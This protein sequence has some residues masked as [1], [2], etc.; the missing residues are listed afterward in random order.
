LSYRISE[1]LQAVTSGDEST[2][3]AMIARGA[4]VDATNDSGQTPLILAIVGG[5][6]RVLRHLMKAGANPLLRD[7]TGLNAIEWAERK[8]RPDLAQLLDP[9]RKPS[10]GSVSVS[11]PKPQVTEPSKEP[12]RQTPLSPEE[13]SRRFLA[14]LRQRFEEKAQLT[15]NPNGSAKEDHMQTQ[16]LIDKLPAVPPPLPTKEEISISDMREPERSSTATAA[17]KP[18]TRKRCPECNRIY[19]SELLS[20]C[21]YHIVPL[22]DANEPVAAPKPTDASPLFWTLVLVTLVAAALVGLLITNSLFENASSPKPA[23]AAL[24][25]TSKKGIPVLGQELTGKAVQLPEAQPPANAVKEPTTVTVRVK[26]GKDGRVNA[27]V[28]NAAE[29][30]VRESAIAAARQATFSVEKLRARSAEG[31]IRYTFNP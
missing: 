22:V 3:A 7:N 17:T 15:K 26:I 30:T 24:T 20:Y 29:R 4:D 27:A 31:T 8:G 5:Q 21:S 18:S 23:P 10:A 16:E 11:A 13:R 9:Y 25:V 2:V 6:P 1:F 14:G 19:N 28:S 12:P